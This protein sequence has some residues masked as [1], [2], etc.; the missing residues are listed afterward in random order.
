MTCTLISL[1]RLQTSWDVTTRCLQMTQLQT[2]SLFDYECRPLEVV[3]D[4]IILHRVERYIVGKPPNA[5]SGFT[6][7]MTADLQEVLLPST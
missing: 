6:S 1:S 4:Y 3:L 7:M 5:R 2:S